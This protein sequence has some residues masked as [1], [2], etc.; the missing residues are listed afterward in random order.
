MREAR[1]VSRRADFTRDDREVISSGFA[2]TRF[3]RLL[4]AV[5]LVRLR[6]A[7]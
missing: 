2:T 7:G 1:R 6:G 4:R 3:C 5:L